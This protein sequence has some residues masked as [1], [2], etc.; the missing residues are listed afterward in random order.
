M[1]SEYKIERCLRPASYEQAES[2]SLHHFADASEVG[3]GTVSYLR[4]E[5]SEG[6]T[7]CSF[8]LSKS[9]V[10]PLKQVSIPR[11]ELTAASVAV[12]I[13]QV[14]KRE[15]PVK[16]TYFWT[17]SQTVLRYIHNTTARFQTFVANRLAVIQDGSSPDQWHYVKSSLNP[18]DAG[19]RG[20]KVQE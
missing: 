1:L 2:I 5:N 14:I 10:A 8:L 3:Y 17:D 18:A 7:R 16:R 12:K 9:R 20:L 6:E 13:D 19:S 4:M 11:M 15:L